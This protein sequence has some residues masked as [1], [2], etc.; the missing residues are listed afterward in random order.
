MCNHYYITLFITITSDVLIKIFKILSFLFLICNFQGT[1]R[2]EYFLHWMLAFISCEIFCFIACLH[3]TERTKF[4]RCNVSIW[5]FYQPSGSWI[6]SA[7]WSLVKPVILTALPCWLGWL[8][9]VLLIP[10][11]IYSKLRQ[12]FC[13][14]FFFFW[15]GGH[16]LSHTV[17][18]AV[19]SAV[20]VLTI[21]FGMGTGVTP[22]RIATKKFC[23]PWWLNN[24]QRL[25]LLLLP[26]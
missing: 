4:L 21:V 6:S 14:R 7:L 13:L 11:C 3:A 19:P 22:E 20:Q 2:N 17:S 10:A 9:E 26:F 12:R 23:H 25:T 15:F 5:L 16:L 18:S 8:D 1:L 24:R